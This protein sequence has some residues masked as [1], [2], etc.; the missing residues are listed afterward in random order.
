MLRTT[1][2][3]PVYNAEKTIERAVLSV[4]RCLAYCTD[5][6]LIAL[7]DCSSDSTFSILNELSI[8]RP[9]LSVHRSTENV[10]P[11]KL[12]NSAIEMANTDFVGFL[13]ADDEIKPEAY[14]N[15][16]RIN[17]ATSSDVITFNAIVK[18][19]GEEKF[20]Y[21]FDRLVTDHDELV[22]LCSRGELDGSVIFSLYSKQ[23]I[24]NHNIR[25]ENWYFEDIPF[26]YKAMMLANQLT[27]HS[28]VCYVKHD[29]DGSIVNSISNKHI[30]GLLHSCFEIYEFTRN[31]PKVD[32]QMARSD[33]EYCLAGYI[34]T[35]LEGIAKHGSL[36]EQHLLLELLSETLKK[37]NVDAYQ[38]FLPTP[39]GTIANRYLTK[40]RQ[41]ASFQI[42]E[43][44]D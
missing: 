19:G 8:T 29:T 30:L 39:K 17:N 10:G 18:N 3:M 1:L 9:Y 20:R 14:M 37:Y 2:I 11:G 41:R 44:F 27:I 21:D 36:K 23:F 13:D 15:M 31:L 43:L 26:A 25:F 4:D 40:L 7:D 32:P 16:L 42:S 5:I 34:S 33:H 6:S 12:R 35:I 28:E 38:N 22:S 24:D